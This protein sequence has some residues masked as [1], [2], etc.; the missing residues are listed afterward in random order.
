MALR[1]CSLMGGGVIS[2]NSAD[3]S[4]PKIRRGDDTDIHVLLHQSFCL[5]RTFVHMLLWYNAV[6]LN[7]I[8]HQMVDTKEET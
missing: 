5:F 3:R 4:L 7:F 2:V 8:H 1:L 6:M